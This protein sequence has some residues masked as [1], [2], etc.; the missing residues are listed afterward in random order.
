LTTKGIIF[1]LDG[2]LVDTLDDL[3]DSMNYALKTLGF[4]PQPP[5]ECRKM[6]GNGLTKFA[7]RAIGVENS[8]QRDRLLEVMTGHYRGNCLNKTRVYE[9]LGEVIKVLQGRGLRLSMLTNKNQEPAEV[10][11]RHFF[12]ANTF[13]PIIGYAA[14]RAVK[15]EPGG[16]LEILKAWGV[17]TEEVVL[18]GDS[19]VDAATAVRAKVRFWGCQ[20]GFRSREQLVAAG[21]KVLIE[22]PG[23]ILEYLDS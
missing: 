1:D 19:E 17:G 15:P 7:E 20:W 16:V 10:I 22:K 12:G 5:Q 18:V 23:E 3:T 4:P 8:G 14:G 9:G 2:T 13:N 11:V 21:A 6:I